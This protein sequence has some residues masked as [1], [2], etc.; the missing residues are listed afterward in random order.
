MNGLGEIKCS[1][2]RR[3]LLG[4][5]VSGLLALLA[6]LAPTAQA[7]APKAASLERRVT[8]LEAMHEIQNLLGYYEE[9]QWALDFEQVVPLFAL[10]AADVRW[11]VGP[12]AYVGADA[13]KAV[14]MAQQKHPDNPQWFAI[15]HGEMHV[16]TLA[17]PIIV[18]AGDG[19][20]A[21]ASFD[22]PGIETLAGATHKP[23]ARWGWCKY[24]VDLLRTEDGWKIWHMHVYGILFSPFDKS[25]VEAP[26]FPSVPSATDVGGEW[27]APTRPQS[28]NWIYSGNDIPPLLPR[29]PVPYRTFSETFSY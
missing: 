29:P 16:H 11:E 28:D 15:H 25:W 14:L 22:S 8:Q 26:G 10:G 3:P 27:P 2:R 18:I 19:K 1:A 13:V 9:Y 6:V 12:G 20:T 23:D 4:G 24:G 7:A 17:T 21:K 5:V